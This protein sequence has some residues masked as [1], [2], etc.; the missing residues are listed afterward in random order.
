MGE[1]AQVIIA[2][3]CLVGVFILTRIGIAWKLNSVSKKIVR[4]LY[5]R[6]AFDT[7]SAVSLPYE[8]PHPIRIGMRDYPSKA[9]EYLVNESVVIRTSSG[10]YYLPPRVRDFMD[11]HDSI[12]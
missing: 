9:L 4:D 11:S 6:G 8:K 3:I 1:T 2:G 10:K 12:P 7:G 5:A